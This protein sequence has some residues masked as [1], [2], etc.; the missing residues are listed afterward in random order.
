M[1]R[2]S[3]TDSSPVKF[4]TKIQG[5]SVDLK[6]RENPLVNLEQQLLK[7]SEF[8]SQIGN[9]LQKQDNYVKEKQII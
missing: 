5:V 4:E 8:E 1:E 7:I 3:L 2:I 9:T 6:N